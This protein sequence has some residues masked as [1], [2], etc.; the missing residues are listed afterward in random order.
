M[1]TLTRAE[2]S[3]H[4]TCEG[5][6]G[7]PLLMLSNSLGANLSMW[8]GQA[9]EFSKSFR[10]LRY[11][12]RGH[13]HSAAP[14]APYSLEDVAND[15]ALLLEHVGVSSAH[16]CGL[17]LGG[18]VGMWLVTHRPELI[19]KLVLCNTSALLGPRENWDARITA[20]K[21]GG[22][23]AIVKATMERWFTEGFRNSSPS[24][25]AQVEQ[26]F[27][28]V[29]VEGYTGCCAAIRDMDQR[30]AIS[31]ISVPT[32]VIAGTHDAATPPAMGQ[33][34]AETIPGARYAELPT[35]HLSNI[36][37]A[38]AFNKVVSEFLG[39]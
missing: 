1:P 10:V 20:V 4:Y 26:S 23:Q 36:E 12:N 15:A 28:K 18:M 6:P 38:P 19:E 37:A 31:R 24:V 33:Y 16:F 34:I 11:D 25:I 32:L 13:G 21:E 35:A 17:S 22:L 9:A 14:R 29:S 2:Y 3:I 7:A 39:V 30:A 8:D 27:L 5:A